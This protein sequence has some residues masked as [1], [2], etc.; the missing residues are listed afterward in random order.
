MPAAK[1]PRPLVLAAVSGLG[2]AGRH[3]RALADALAGELGREVVPSL[4]PSYADLAGEI[5]AGAADLAWA[6]PLVALEL[7]R[8]GHAHVAVCSSRAGA[9][10]YHA[11]LFTQHT[12]KLEKL[13]DLRG[14]HV[15]WVDKQSS[16]GY[17]VPRLHLAQVG[18]EP[19]KLFGKE[20]FLGSHEKVSL[21][22]LAGEVDV[23]ATYVSL[24]PVS[25]RAISAGWLE[26]GAAVNG[27]FVLAMFG[28]IPSDAVVIT[29]RLDDEALVASL[30]SALLAL[31]AAVP[32]SVGRLLRADGLVVPP[33]G[34]FDALR[35]LV[36]K[37]A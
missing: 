5:S 18:L 17:V 21:A 26:A 12:S 14:A 22:V 23:G 2:S 6:P 4:L 13:E 35:K 3:L 8:A 20:S 27:A 37:P 29:T 31:P 9:I 15:A 24:D 7:E 28:P 11:A 36:A 16:A 10:D 1:P 33:A 25:K 32:Q 34:H 19:S 30:T